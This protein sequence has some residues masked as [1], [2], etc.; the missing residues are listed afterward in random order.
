MTASNFPARQLREP[1]LAVE[2]MVANTAWKVSVVKP[3]PPKAV[4]EGQ[5]LQRERPHQTWAP[6]PLGS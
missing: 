5:A 3:L 1:G 6:A 4:A 2:R